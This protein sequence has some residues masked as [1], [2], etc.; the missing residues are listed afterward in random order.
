MTRN[1]WRSRGL[2]LGVAAAL[3]AI[4][5]GCGTSDRTNAQEERFV[6]IGKPK[7]SSSGLYT[8]SVK[9]GPEENSVKTWI[10]VINDT[11]GTEVFRD[12]YAYSPRHRL[13][14]TWLSGHDQLWILSSDVGTSHIDRQPDGTWKKIDI[15]P[16]TLGEVPAEINQY[17]HR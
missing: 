17:R 5:M 11:S 9:F 12:D 8:A 13:T 4:L 2:L 6:G 7:L 15:T 16:E 14:I 3:V 10:A 1:N